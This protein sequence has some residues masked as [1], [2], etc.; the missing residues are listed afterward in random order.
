MD[1]VSGVLAFSCEIW[2]FEID[3]DGLILPI[4][5]HPILSDSPSC[6][7]FVFLLLRL[8]K[9][10]TKTGFFEETSIIVL[11]NIIF[12]CIF[13]AILG[14]IQVL[15]NNFSEVHVSDWNSMESSLN[16]FFRS[17]TKLFVFGSP[18]TMYFLLAIIIWSIKQFVSQAIFIKK[19]N[20][21]FI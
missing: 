19:E 11:N 4:A 20:E 15:F 8:F 13:L 1:F 6:I 12:S 14:T 17:F 7:S 16:L 2:D 5:Y 18:Q 21:S 9:K 3:F 10:Y